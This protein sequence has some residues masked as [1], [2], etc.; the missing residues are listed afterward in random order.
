MSDEKKAEQQKDQVV[1]A[2]DVVVEKW[3]IDTF[4]NRGISGEEYNRLVA[5]KNDLKARLARA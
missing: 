1:N 3:F 4:H 5:A 2:A